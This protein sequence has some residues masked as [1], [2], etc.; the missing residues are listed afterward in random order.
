MIQGSQQVIHLNEVWNRE[1]QQGDKDHKTLQLL[2]SN[3]SVLSKDEND[4]KKAMRY[5]NRR[6]RNHQQVY[7][8]QDINNNKASTV[9]ER[10]NFHDTR[11]KFEPKTGEEKV[12]M[13]DSNKSN[14]GTKTRNVNNEKQ[15]SEIRYQLKPVDDAEAEL[16]KILDS[17]DNA[18]VIDE[19]HFKEKE[20]EKIQGD[21]TRKHP[22]SMVSLL[23]ATDC[24]EYF[25]NEHLQLLIHFLPM[26]LSLAQL[27]FYRQER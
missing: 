9:P 6:D 14:Y 2:G 7:H 23:T 5:L 17:D 3:D 27:F 1:T 10:R 4:L 19:E 20:V 11:L 16:S 12:Q 18:A 15:H 25:S 8:S 22:K 13:K 24:I 21:R 26:C